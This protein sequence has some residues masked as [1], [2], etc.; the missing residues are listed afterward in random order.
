MSS[1]G[2]QTFGKARDTQGG[3]TWEV[4]SARESSRQQTLAE[5]WAEGLD[6]CREKFWLGVWKG[7]WGG[8]PKLGTSPKAP[9]CQAERELGATQPIKLWLVMGCGL[10][11]V[12]VHLR[13]T[14]SRQGSHGELF[15]HLSLF[16]SDCSTKPRLGWAA[17]VGRGSWEKVFLK[18]R[19]FFAWFFL[20]IH[21]SGKENKNRSGFLNL[22]APEAIIE[23][24][25]SK[26]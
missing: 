21:R 15:T 14:P 12:R 1:T 18:K 5:P 24:N 11:Q 19:T 20:P 9:A 10:V 26:S 17:F 2:E 23:Q 4:N 25:V 6:S 3:A 22:G 16:N 8:H 13:L 7:T